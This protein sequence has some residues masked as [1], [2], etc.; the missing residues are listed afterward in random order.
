MINIYMIIAIVVL[1][2]ILLIVFKVFKRVLKLLVYMAIFALAVFIVF[3]FF[4]YQDMRTFEQRF[5]DTPSLFLF[6]E[7]SEMLFGF[8]SVG[9][10]T[11]IELLS[12]E[13]LSSIQIAY[14]NL[15]LEDIITEEYKIFIFNKSLF[16]EPL[17]EGFKNAFTDPSFMFREIANENIEVYPETPLFYAVKNIP[18]LQSIKVGTM[19]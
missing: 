1:F 13:T 4:V 5:L 17:D 18:F 3:G 12:E 10:S 8:K 2:F 9:V 14:D 19:G 16:T 15:A 6:Q 7:Q 11:D